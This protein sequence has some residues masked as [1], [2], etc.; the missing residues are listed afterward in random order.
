MSTNI[1]KDG[2]YASLGMPNLGALL[3]EEDTEAIKNYLLSLRA[4]LIK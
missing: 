3:N 1:V 2:A 4:D